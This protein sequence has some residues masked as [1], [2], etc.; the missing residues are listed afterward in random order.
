MAPS[1]SGLITGRSESWKKAAKLTS[2]SLAAE[3]LFARASTEAT[4]PQGPAPRFR[5]YLVKTRLI[6]GTAQ[7]DTQRFFLLF[8]HHLRKI[9][10]A[11]ISAYASADGMWRT[12]WWLVAWAHR[13]IG[14]GYAASGHDPAM[15]LTRDSHRVRRVSTLLLLLSAPEGS[16]LF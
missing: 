7:I 9:T 8:D 10:E 3:V 11:P 4:A 2:N 16:C 6:I 14:F 13:P 1:A 12:Y 5:A 15:G